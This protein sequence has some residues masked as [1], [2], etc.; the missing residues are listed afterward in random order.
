M[1]GSARCRSFRC[2]TLL[3]RLPEK[4]SAPSRLNAYG[5]DLVTVPCDHRPNCAGKS[6]SLVRVMLKRYPGACVM[7]G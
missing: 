6:M 2:A 5:A 7:V 4:K 3:H 1:L